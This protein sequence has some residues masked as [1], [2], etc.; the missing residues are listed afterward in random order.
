MPSN[1]TAAQDR[2]VNSAAS[3][4]DEITDTVA[5][6]LSIISD[7]D[8]RLSSALEDVATKESELNE[9]NDTIADLTYQL[10]GAR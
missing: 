4:A 7:L 5:N 6:L 8:D 10:E 1:T 9:A 2:A 3:H